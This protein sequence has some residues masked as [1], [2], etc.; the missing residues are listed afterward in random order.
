MKG[1][2]G[3]QPLVLIE[4]PPVR[5]AGPACLILMIKKINLVFKNKNRVW[6]EPD[7]NL[8]KPR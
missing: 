5:M 2:A 7:A 3:K 1:Y 8:F 6:S 4:N